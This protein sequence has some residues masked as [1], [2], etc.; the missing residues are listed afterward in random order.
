MWVL[1]TGGEYAQALKPETEY[2]SNV[3]GVITVK[4]SQTGSKA[5]LKRGSQHT[6]TPKGRQLCPAAR[7]WP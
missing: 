2:Q 7:E 3:L 1:G 4:T 5:W 6:V